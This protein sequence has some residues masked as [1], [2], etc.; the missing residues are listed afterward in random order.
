MRLRRHQTL[1]RQGSRLPRSRK[2]PCSVWRKGPCYHTPR[3]SPPHRPSFR[4]EI[5]GSC[6]HTPR[7]WSPCFDSPLER[8]AGPC[9]QTRRLWRPNV[10]LG[11]GPCFPTLRFLTPCLLSSIVPSGNEGSWC[12]H[13]RRLWLPVGLLRPSFLFT[14]VFVVEPINRWN[15]EGPCSHTRRLCPRGHTKP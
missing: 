6:F 15:D 10:L 14:A 12:D 11:K 5:E 8:Q 3:F 7:L 4:M 1:K 2:K 9:A 13:T